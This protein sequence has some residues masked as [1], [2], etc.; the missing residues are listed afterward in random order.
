MCKKI[1]NINTSLIKI[2]H[3]SDG[4]I[5]LDFNTTMEDLLK[6]IAILGDKLE[7]EVSVKEP[8]TY[9]LSE[10]ETARVVSSSEAVNLIIDGEKL[11]VTTK[12][13]GEK[14]KELNINLRKLNIPAQSGELSVSFFYINEDICYYFL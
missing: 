11:T 2:E 12:Y 5:K 3:L 13:L 7:G 9:T 6:D 1:K 10:G 4:L 8:F 14:K